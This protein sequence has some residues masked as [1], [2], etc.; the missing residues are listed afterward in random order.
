MAYGGR[1]D[2]L[3][4]GAILQ[5]GGAFPLTPPNTTVFQSTFDLLFNGTNC[6]S[7]ANGSASDKLDC[8]RK[9][10]VD[11][12]R[13]KVGSSTGQSADGDFTRTSIQRA[14][15]AGQYV[16]IPTIVGSE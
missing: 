10:P 2:G 1:D 7:L 16:K 4:R 9:L 3:F 6:S 13:A 5:S 14:L 12:F 11:I 15:P 8:I